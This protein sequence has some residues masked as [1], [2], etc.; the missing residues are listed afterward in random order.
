MECTEGSH[1]LAMV[2]LPCSYALI[3][4]CHL[5]RDDACACSVGTE[6]D[7]VKTTLDERGS[8]ISDATP[9]VKI[10]AAIAQLKV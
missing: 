6:L 7:T 4:L 2:P 1:C 9:L 5:H 10:R 3:A 8:N